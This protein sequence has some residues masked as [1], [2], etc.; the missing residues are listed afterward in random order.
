MISP[1]LGIP[2]LAIYAIKT[3]RVEFKNVGLYPKYA[4]LDHNLTKSLP[5]KLSL[6]TTM[7]ALSHSLESIWNKHR[8][9]KTIDYAIN[10]ITLIMNDACK[11]SKQKMTVTSRKNLLYASTLAGLAFSNTKTA[12]AHSISYPLTIHYDIPHGI[13]SS[14]TL[15]PLLIFSESKIKTE[16]NQI[17]INSD[18]KNLDDFI[19]KIISIYN[20]NISY[21]LKDWGVKKEDLSDL[22]KKCYTKDRIENYIIDV[23]EQDILKIL[24][25]IY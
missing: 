16:L 9:Q 18:I 19:S 15:I 6:S 5:I 10:A 1:D 3:D 23:S 17:Y 20:E 14:M 21:H 11:I 12:I 24:E 7:D 2:R 8:T 25:A 22:V 13:A 4:I